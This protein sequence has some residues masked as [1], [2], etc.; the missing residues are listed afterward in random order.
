[1]L[2]GSHIKISNLANHTKKQNKKYQNAKSIGEK[3][4]SKGLIFF[5][6]FFSWILDANDDSYFYFE[7]T[8]QFELF[9][10]AF[11]LLQKIPPTSF[12]AISFLK[13]QIE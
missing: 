1:M 4:K 7:Q 10:Q 12:S 13:L 3:L 8:N 9:L 6:S 11:S 5:V 2:C